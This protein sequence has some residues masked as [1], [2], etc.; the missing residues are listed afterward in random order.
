M[1]VKLGR[2]AGRPAELHEL[3]VKIF[4]ALYGRDFLAE[5]DLLNAL[6]LDRISL[7]QLNALSRD[8]YVGGAAA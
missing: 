8:G 3:G 6:D 5:N 7:D 1:T 4:S 2:L